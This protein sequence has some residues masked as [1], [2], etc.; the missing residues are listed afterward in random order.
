MVFGMPNVL[1]ETVEKNKFLKRFKNLNITATKQD[2][3]EF[4]AIDNESTHVF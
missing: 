1:T 4:V 2:I 3:D